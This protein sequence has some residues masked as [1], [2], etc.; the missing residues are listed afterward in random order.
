VLSRVLSG[1]CGERRP[2]DQPNPQEKGLN[3]VLGVH[4][5]VSSRCRDVGTFAPKDAE[6]PV[7]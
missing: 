5:G 7:V 1:L 4:I 2:A 6:L 3:A